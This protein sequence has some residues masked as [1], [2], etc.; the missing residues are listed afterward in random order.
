MAHHFVSKKL[1]K[2]LKKE[3]K[4][5]DAMMW[6]AGLLGPAT[7]LPQLYMIYST[8]SA[9]DLSLVSWGFFLVLCTVYFC[10]AII[11]KIKPLAVAQFLWLVVYGAITVGIILY[12]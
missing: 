8:Q 2:S 12:D 9:K 5:I 10:Y 3:Q 6:L 11:H 1:Y 4:E 7:A